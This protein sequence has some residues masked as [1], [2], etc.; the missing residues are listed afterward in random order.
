MSL[1]TLYTTKELAEKF[2]THYM[3]IRNWRKSGKLQG[4]KIRGKVFFKEEEVLK[5]LE[6]KEDR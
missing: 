5:L 2:G 4:V 1:P 6:V 3:T